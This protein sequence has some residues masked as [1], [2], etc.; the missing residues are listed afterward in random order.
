MTKILIV[1]DDR[2]IRLTLSIFFERKGYR[3]RDVA[4]VSAA[5]NALKEFRAD[6]VLTDLKMEGQGGLE[7]LTSVKATWPLLPV[8]VMTAY[9]TIEKAVTAMKLGASDFIVKPFSPAEIESV[10]C[11][12]LIQL[13]AESTSS[14]GT[15][16]ADLL[17]RSDSFKRTLRLAERFARSEATVL[18]LGESGTG[19]SLLARCIHQLSMRS[20]HVFVEVNCA[21]LSS[22][23]L[24]SELF[25]HCRGAFTGAIK[26]KVGRLEAAHQGTLFL[27]EISELSPEGQTK[28]LRFLQDK[29]CERVGEMKVRAV[30]ARIIAASNRD[31]RALVSREG[32][33]ED[34][35]YRLNVA[36]IMMPS[37]RE[38][39]EDISF[40]ASQFLSQIATRNGFPSRPIL[41]AEMLAL[42]ERYNWPGNVRELLNVMERC[43]ILAGGASISIEHLPDYIR[44]GPVSRASGQS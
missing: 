16:E 3:V 25:G 35:Y 26:D 38:R 22:T 28:L 18:I 11:R 27:D 37:L 20:N 29:V 36:E 1:D 19:K 17:T 23:L 32:F 15:L 14:S 5:L 43:A 31:L 12:N 4:S 39:P 33:R 42:L 21:S 8:I 40:L 2:T 44:V 30:D 13:P 41:S 7:L 9:G 6:I 10:L 34:L 24:E